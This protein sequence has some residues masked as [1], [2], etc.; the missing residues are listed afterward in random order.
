MEKYG[1]VRQTADENIIRHVQIACLS[2]LTDTLSQYVYSLHFCGN[3]DFMN[4]PHCSVICTLPIFLL[5]WIMQKHFK[6][7]Y[8]QCGETQDKVCH[9]MQTLNPH[10]FLVCFLF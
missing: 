3:N 1:T 4:M 9:W 10:F 2:K 8:F 5:L 7:K 6:R